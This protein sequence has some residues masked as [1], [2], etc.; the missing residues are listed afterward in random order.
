MST[1]PD[2]WTHRIATDAARAERLLPGP[3]ERVW[4]HLV[5]PALRALWLAGGPIAS[6]VG[7]EVDLVFRHDT[8]SDE[9]GDAPAAY[10]DMA[11]GHHNAGVVT[12]WD[13]PRRLAFTWA[14]N[15]AD[16]SEVTFELAPRGDAVLLVV[17]HRRLDGIDA[18]RSVA[19]GWHAHLDILADRLHGRAPG[20]FWVAHGRLEAAYAD[21]FAD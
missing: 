17:T 21:R 3:I 10:A 18:L 2:A 14:E 9:P 16:A 12:A 15:H 13:P 1:T 4:D 6:H 20:N 5:D 19:A 7:G 11:G 8:L